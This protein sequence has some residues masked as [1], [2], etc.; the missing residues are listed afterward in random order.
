MQRLSSR[1]MASMPEVHWNKQ[2]PKAMAMS[3]MTDQAEFC[4]VPQSQLPDRILSF[5]ENN[6]LPV[7]ID[8]KKCN[9]KEKKTA[10]CLKS[11]RTKAKMAPMRTG[12]MNCDLRELKVK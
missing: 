10:P 5:M 8:K 3:T 6:D 11:Q 12:K 4:E 7:F 9:I 2:T 1:A